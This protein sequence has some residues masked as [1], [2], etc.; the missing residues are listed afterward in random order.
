MP[1]IDT[2]ILI[3]APLEK[4]YAIAKDNSSYPDFMKDVQSVTVVER[5]GNRVVSDFVGLVP[6]FNLKV[7]WR[8]EDLWDDETHS[9]Q[10]RQ[11]EGDYDRMTGTWQFTQEG[12]DV[13]FTQHLDYEYNVP[14]LGPLV[15]KVVHSLVVKNLENLAKAIK[16]RAEAQSKA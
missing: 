9:S 12:K 8:E 11:I 15:R 13:R 16:E 10:F 5:S 14:T 1:T 4:I 2:T 7:R 3:S 6:T